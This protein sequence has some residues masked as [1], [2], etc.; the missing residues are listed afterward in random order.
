MVKNNTVG[1]P[2]RLGHWYHWDMYQIMLWFLQG[3]NINNNKLTHY[4]II[5]FINL[6]MSWLNTFLQGLKMVYAGINMFSMC[7]CLDTWLLQGYF[8]VINDLQATW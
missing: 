7:Y 8:T 2:V 4:N 3:H 6:T 1:T 5:I